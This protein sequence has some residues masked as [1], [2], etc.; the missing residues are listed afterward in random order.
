M[1]RLRTAAFECIWIRASTGGGGGR[2]DRRT[3]PAS[4]PAGTRRLPRTGIESVNRRGSGGRRQ[5]RCRPHAPRFTFYPSGHHDLIHSNE[6]T[7]LPKPRGHAA[8]CRRF[9]GASRERERGFVSLAGI[10]ASFLAA[11]VSHRRRTGRA[12]RGARHELGDRREVARP[13]A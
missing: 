6:V 8:V 1:F 13:R 7:A 5:A 12:A 10:G 11:G 9:A 3:A 2:E 4:A